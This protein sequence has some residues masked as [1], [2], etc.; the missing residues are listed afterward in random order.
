MVDPT[1]R[2]RESYRQKRGTGMEEQARE[3]WRGRERERE[4]ER[5]KES[6]SGSGGGERDLNRLKEEK[7]G[8]NKKEPARWKAI[9]KERDCGR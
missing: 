2:E 3:T 1:D 5:E 9:E 4:R 7:E 6:E 8:R